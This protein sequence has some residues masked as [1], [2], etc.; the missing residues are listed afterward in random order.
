MLRITL[1]NVTLFSLAGGHVV[2]DSFVQNQINRHIEDMAAPGDYLESTL[3][4][5]LALQASNP[6]PREARLDTW[7]PNTVKK[8]LTELQ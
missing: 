3:K 4:S 5:E 2:A 8:L 7:P 1:I 6:T